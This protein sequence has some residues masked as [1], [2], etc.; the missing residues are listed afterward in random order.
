MLC[1]YAGLRHPNKLVKQ[2]TR[3]VQLARREQRA[4]RFRGLAVR[5]RRKAARPFGEILQP[6]VDFLLKLLDRYA[7]TLHT[8]RDRLFHHR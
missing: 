3:F 5:L 1:Y 4:G 6:S 8:F 2:R 7:A